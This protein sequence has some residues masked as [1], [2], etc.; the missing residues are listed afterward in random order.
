[1]LLK[2]SLHPGRSNW[3]SAKPLKTVARPGPE[4]QRAHVLTGPVDQR[5]LAEDALRVVLDQ[6]PLLEAIRAMIV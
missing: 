2:R 6:S 5:D 4:Q 3:M 1:M